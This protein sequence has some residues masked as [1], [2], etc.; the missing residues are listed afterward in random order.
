VFY[1]KV[2]CKM[3]DILKSCSSS[4]SAYFYTFR[5]RSRKR[6]LEMNVSLHNE[7]IIPLFCYNVPVLTVLYKL[8]RREFIA[9]SIGSA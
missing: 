3:F 8:N 4:Q 6:L 5:P 2:N 1:M 7:K 9:N